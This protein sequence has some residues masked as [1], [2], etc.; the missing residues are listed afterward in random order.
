MRAYC[1]IGGTDCEGEDYLSLRLFEF[2]STAEMYQNDLKEGTNNSGYNEGM[3]MYD[4]TIM[5]IQTAITES[6]LWA[7]K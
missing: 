6:K 7:P 5:E 4:Y 3:T 1:V 2:K